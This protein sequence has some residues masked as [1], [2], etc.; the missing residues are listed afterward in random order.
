MNMNGAAIQ[1]QIC[2][3]KEAIMKSMQGTK[4]MEG[5]ELT[6]MIESAQLFPELRYA[7]LGYTTTLLGVDGADYKVEIV[8]PSGSKSFDWYNVESGL[9]T[10]SENQD[11]L[12][13]LSDYK[14]FKGVKFPMITEMSAGPQ[15]LIMKVDVLKV[16]SGISSSK[17]AVK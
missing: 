9:R 16:N 15:Q 11:G 12:Q 6:K 10:K 2:N 13:I 4:M 14:T 3:G 8:S 7:E 17:F 1:T 5:E